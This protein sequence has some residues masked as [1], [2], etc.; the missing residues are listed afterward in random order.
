MKKNNY[1]P[2]VVSSLHGF[3]SHG[4]WQA[5]LSNFIAT[6]KIPTFNF[7]YG[8]KF[9]SCLVPGFKK[10]LVK[11]FY[12]QYSIF[13][14]HKDY[15]ID[16][17]N[18]NRRP[19]IV[20]H[21]L[22]SYILCQA[23]LK[24][25]D[26]KFDKIILCGSIV[27]IDYD[28]DTI[29][30]RN[31]VHFVRNEYSPSDSVVK[32]G[33]I[34]TNSNKNFSGWRGFSCISNAL[35]QEKFD[36]Y[37]HGTFFEGNHMENHWLPFFLKSP[38]EFNVIRGKEIETINQFTNYFDQSVQIDLDCYGN[39]PHYS[40]YTIP[41]GFAEKWVQSNND[42]YSFL[43]KGENNEELIGY[44]NAM[45]LKKEVFQ[46]LLN[47]EV[48]DSD[49]THKNILPYDGYNKEIHLYIM[50]IALSPN[51]Q[52]Q[53]LGLKDL[54]FE[55][56]FNSLLDKLTEYYNK[57]G[58]KVVQIA[59]VGWTE[60][61]IRLSKML[62]MKDSGKFEQ[63]TNKPIFILELNDK[64]DRSNTHKGILKLLELYNN[65]KI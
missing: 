17:R 7:D 39:D 48:H 1:S 5:S 24:Y 37:D 27:D 19:S 29:F 41:D 18:P 22:G 25:P 43:T 6:K 54:G 9:L 31:Q 26:I 49:I 13:V 65:D 62:G 2:N 50:S 8:Y 46:S 42:I 32:W 21:S 12:D 59:S 15:K 57:Y 53:H 33:W 4:K 28:W 14:K 34:L 56:L 63:E 61:G 23:L 55:K 38:P 11:E 58:I 64:I 47:G 60:K 3:K 16:I 51:Y 36:H 40:E 10:R 30:K 52:M 20:A 44:I 35:D 45:P